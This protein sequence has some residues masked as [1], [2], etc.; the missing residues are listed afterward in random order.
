[1]VRIAIDAMGAEGGLEVVVNGAKEAY[2]KYSSDIILVGNKQELLKYNLDGIDIHNASE[3]IGMDEEPMPAVKNKR[4]SS[5]VRATKLVGG[6]DADILLSPGNTGATVAASAIFLKRLYKKQRLAIATTIPNDKREF[7][8]LL[9]SGASSSS[10]C[11]EKDLFY[12]ALMGSSFYHYLFGKENP[13]IGLINVGKEE[14]KGPEEVKKANK[15]LEN[16][17]LNYVGFVE[18]NDIPFGKVDVAVCDGYV[19]NVLLKGY[20]GI[21]N[22]IRATIKEAF[23]KSLLRKIGAGILKYG[24]AFDYIQNRFNQESYGGGFLLGLK[25]PVVIAHGSSS[26]RSIENA[27][28]FAEKCAKACEQI[29]PKLEEAIIEYKHLLTK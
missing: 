10:K 23:S 12:F 26:S 6:G 7:T 11:D 1:M 24:G 14:Y 3:V 20:E 4:D 19:G 22:L 8:V 25:K 2:Q 9:D 21:A 28:Y 16:S 15:L 29:N 5:I 17:N 18:G 13:S 27:I